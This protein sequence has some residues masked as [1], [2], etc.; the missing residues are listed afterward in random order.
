MAHKIF[1][2]GS[3]FAAHRPSSCGVRAQLLWP[4][5]SVAQECGILVP[6]SGIELMP[7]AL[8]GGFLI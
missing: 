1:A 5:D 7:P 3:F 2:A 6:Q 8:E 4:A